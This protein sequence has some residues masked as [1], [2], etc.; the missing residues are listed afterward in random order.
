MFQGKLSCV[1]T[2]PDSS[3]CV[4][5]LDVSAPPPSIDR[6]PTQLGEAL[7]HFERA[8]TSKA[9]L[10]GI[11][12]GGQDGLVDVMMHNAKTT[13]GHPGKSGGQMAVIGTISA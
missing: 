6:L 9:S 8:Q 11:I 10:S 2:L 3:L 4:K 12:L 5:E 7:R 13:V 1:L